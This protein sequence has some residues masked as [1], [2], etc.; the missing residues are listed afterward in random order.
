MRYDA[1]GRDKIT[2]DPVLTQIS[3][4][5]ENNA[6]GYVASR[7]A[8]KVRVTEKS[9]RYEV[10]GPRAFRRHFGG[11]NRAPGARAN[12]TSGRRVYAEDTYTSNEKALEEL[13]PD[14]ENEE[15]PAG[16][17]PEGEAVE[18]LT[19]D[20]LLGKEL[21]VRDLLYDPTVYHTDHT[22]TLGAGEKFDEYSTSDPFGVFREIMRTFHRSVGILPN[23]AVMPWRVMSYLVD[24][25]Q[26]LQRYALRGGVI[27]PEMVAEALGLREVIVPGT[28]YDD[29]NPG[30]NV[31]IT[32]IWGNDN[33]VLGI[34]PP[35]PARG[36][37][38]VAYEFLHPI[39]G[40]GRRS[41]DDVQVD[42]RRDGDRIG[43]INRVR[44]RY[45]V[46]LVG[47][48]PDQVGSPLVAAYLLRNV[49]V[50]NA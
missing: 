20:L 19:A 17:N 5:F 15:A 32:D 42:R 45:D 39:P 26:L 25:P 22:E 44:R 24:H 27:T 12:E 23:V 28:N 10:F 34:V 11:D 9:G 3:I 33:I 48:D 6:G 38:A 8:P 40:G 37:P 7:L 13:T 30:Q 1:A 47:R 46:K 29:S 21:R 35:R 31:N 14:E 18:A 41:E 36:V 2:P 16:A 49:L 50:D 43:W 4:E